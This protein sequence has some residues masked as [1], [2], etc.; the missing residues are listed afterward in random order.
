[1]TLFLGI[2]VNR[3]GRAFHL[4]INLIQISFYIVAL[5]FQFSHINLN[6]VSLTFCDGSRNLVTLLSHICNGAF[7]SC[8]NLF[9]SL[10][11]LDQF[12]QFFIFIGIIGV[13]KNL[14]L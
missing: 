9:Q 8:L 3:R 2:L 10:A 5:Q 11:G 13:Q 6:N 14:F 1:M 7:R 12:Q 4:L